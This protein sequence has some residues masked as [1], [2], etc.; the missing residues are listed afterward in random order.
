M[1]ITLD[2]QQHGTAETEIMMEGE[3]RRGKRQRERERTGSA[4]CERTSHR[5]NSAVSREELERWREGGMRHK[6]RRGEEGNR[7]TIWGFLYRAQTRL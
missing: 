3:A 7:E 5:E 2:S 1:M 6:R 4:G